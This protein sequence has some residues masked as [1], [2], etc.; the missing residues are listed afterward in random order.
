MS[1]P[2]QSNKTQAGC[3]PISSNCVIWQGPDIPCINLCNG[4]TV[5]DV[6]AKLA[7]KLC[8]IV[9][10]LDISL[11][12][13][14]CFDPLCPTPENFQDL[15][16]ILIDKICALEN[17]EDPTSSSTSCPDDCMVTIASC[18]QE[19]DF[20]GNI[21]T[22]LSLK[23]YVIKI[24]NEICTILTQISTIQ[25][26]ITDLDTRVSTIEENCCGDDDTTVPSSCLSGG[27]DL[28]IVTFVTQLETAFCTLKDDVGTVSDVLAA[29]CLDGNEVQLNDNLNQLHNLPGWVTGPTT[30]SGSVVDLWLALCDMRSY[31]QTAIP[32]LEAQITACC[33]L[34]CS[35]VTW[36]FSAVG[37]VGAKDIIPTFIGS[38]PASFQNYGCATVAAAITVTDAFGNSTVYNEDVID[39][40]VNGTPISLDIS[41][42]G[43]GITE[44]SVYYD[45]SV[46]LCVEDSTPTTCNTTRTV[47][48]YNQFWCT[49]IGATTSSPG[50]GTIQ[51]NWTSA[52]P[53]V[54]TT[55]EITVYESGNPIAVDSGSVTLLVG[56][57][58]TFPFVGLTTGNTYYTVIRSVQNGK[59]IDCVTTPVICA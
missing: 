53:G 27:T 48:I 45:I 34:D 24:G 13:L 1:L 51:A 31:I 5:S 44:N 4:D 58:Q 35:D 21:I 29:Q 10:Q 41:A 12:D 39:S 50:A 26:S 16:Q 15:V 14:S 19:P 54:S 33:A 17:A 56:G 46:N 52:A 32:A 18:F 47:S 25:T 43:G 36:S 3:N 11:L 8:T 59:Y 7:E 2:I 23:D 30:L 28:P 22:S 37:I 55:Y 38:I 49:Y 20:L 57:A 40:I 42:G 9:D 6:V